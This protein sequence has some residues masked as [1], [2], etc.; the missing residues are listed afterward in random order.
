MT[1]ILQALEI[2]GYASTALVIV[3][4][5]ATIVL[6]ILG[7]TPALL[8]LGNGLAR[9]KI[10]IF[11]KGDMASSL[12]SLLLDSRLFR[13]RN[14]VTITDDG[15]IG[16]ARGTT[17]FVVHWP[18]WTTTIDAI[19]AQKADSVA[20]IVYAPQEKGFIPQDVLGR[21][22]GNRNVIVCNFR[23]R[24]LNDI[25]TSLITTSYESPR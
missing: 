25:V 4:T 18:D 21:L 8:R 23:G 17:L 10:A 13:D 16:K 9:R 12:K 24:L 22:N 19:L 1:T 15:D 14:L 20:L 7:I 5:V 6:W 3:A 11:A 2:L